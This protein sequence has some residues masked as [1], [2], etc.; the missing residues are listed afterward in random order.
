MA[1]LLAHLSRC[2]QRR[3]LST[4][5]APPLALGDAAGLRA[6]HAAFLR[7]YGGVPD[8]IHAWMSSF[9]RRPHPE[10]LPAVFLQAALT[11][12][13]LQGA[14]AL[15]F[16]AFL[17]ALLPRLCASEGDA[18]GVVAACAAALGCAHGEGVSEALLLGGEERLDTV[19]RALAL[20]GVP[21]CDAV[22]A[23]VSAEWGQGLAQAW[24]AEDARG[25]SG[26]APWGGAP[27]GWEGASRED[28]AALAASL[29]PRAPPRLR[30]PVLRWPIP[31]QNLAAF[32]LALREQPS[33][34]YGA[35]RH[36]FARTR[37]MHALAAR[38]PRGSPQAATFALLA[39]PLAAEVTQALTDALWGHFYATGDAAAVQRVLDIATG[40][41]EFVEEFGA[42]PFSAP[43][44][45]CALPAA[46]EDSPDAAM[47]FAASRHA[48][49]TLLW[50]CERHTAV[51][52]A[53]SAGYAQLNDRAV[54]EDFAGCASAEGGEGGGGGGGGITAFG[55]AQLDLLHYLRPSL[56]ALAAQAWRRGIGS[57]VWPEAYAALHG[58]EGGGAGGRG[59]LLG[60][61]EGAAGN[62]RGAG[63]AA[64]GA[65]SSLMAAAVRDR[66]R[67][68][69]EQRPL[70]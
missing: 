32:E 40:Y 44:G 65:R 24:G 59:R 53:L 16:A 9:Y 37:A 11:P 17:A 15:P 68:G 38:A 27:P 30:E 57:G 69:W 64:A 6:Q 49:W 51:G 29:G 19:L 60:E 58:E 45:A 26:G 31:V 14:T 54:L 7:I 2:F 48:L 36:L 42:A 55:R 66:R 8:P 34:L 3:A 47:R 35:T 18:D 20:A 63:G 5:L 25:G 46:L 41:G 56:A 28:L 4:A 10:F 21:G 12:G 13:A 43:D 33:P 61:G 50:H 39:P 70:R 62:G 22:L 52:D 67:S 23:R 1:P